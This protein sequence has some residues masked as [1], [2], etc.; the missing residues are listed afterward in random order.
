MHPLKPG[1]GE[2][3]TP[4][5]E[6]KIAEINYRFFPQFK[7]QILTKINPRRDIYKLMF[8]SRSG[9]SRSTAVNSQ[10]SF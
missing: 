9:R 7:I 2:L 8:R 4:P 3:D 1:S 6:W 5:N 10:T